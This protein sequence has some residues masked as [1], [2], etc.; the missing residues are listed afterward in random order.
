MEKPN[1]NYVSKDYVIKIAKGVLGAI[2]LVGGVLGE[3][4]DIAVYPQQQKQLDEW[5]GYVNTTL[6]QLIETG[7]KTREEIFNDEEFISIFQKTSRI[8]SGNV[9]KH[10]KP[11]LKAFLK[12]AITKQMPFDKKYIFLKIIDELTEAQL[13][14]LK[15]IYDNEE[16]ES[17][18]FQKPLEAML[19]EKYANGDNQYLSLLTKGLQDFHLLEFGTAGLRGD[20]TQWYMHTSNIGKEFFEYLLED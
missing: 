4:L 11:L 8:Y 2:P 15:D 10:K 16:S 14:I 13:L 9:E 12:A 6:Q 1:T 3:L 5:L 19:V 17:H 18:L 20:I 7:K